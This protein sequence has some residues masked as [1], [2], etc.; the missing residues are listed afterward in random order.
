LRNGPRPKTGAVSFI[1]VGGST[2]AEF[3]HPSAVSWRSSSQTI[4]LEGRCSIQLSYR[5]R[6]CRTPT[7]YLPSL[8]PVT[9]SQNPSQLVGPPRSGRSA[10]PYPTSPCVARLNSRKVKNPVQGIACALDE[11]E[12]DFR[13]F[14]S[15]L[16]GIGPHP[17]IPDDPVH[18]T[19]TPKNVGVST[20]GTCLQ[21]TSTVYQ[22]VLR[23][24]K[25]APQ[26]RV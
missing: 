25:T 4:G 26:C 17:C 15:V 7:W 6:A 3:P 1:E 19:L 8:R 14:E 5:P 2:L 9:Q 24:R 21:P 20:P 12:K 11:P 18:G 22:P 16:R 23:C 13:G 10:S